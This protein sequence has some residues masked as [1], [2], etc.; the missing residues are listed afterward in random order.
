MIPLL[1][2]LV[3]CQ[4]NQC[5]PIRWSLVSPFCGDFGRSL[6][7]KAPLRRGFCFLVV[8][9][10]NSPPEWGLNDCCSLMINERMCQYFLASPQPNALSAMRLSVATRIYRRVS[11]VFH[12]FHRQMSTHP[13]NARHRVECHDIILITAASGALSN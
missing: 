2:T 11:V 13:E 12:S 8:S 7:V 6:Q 5:L 9:Q 4:R 1:V 10:K 3:G